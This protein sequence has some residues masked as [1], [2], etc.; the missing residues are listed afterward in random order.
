MARNNAPEIVPA[1]SDYLD[2][3]ARY[4]PDEFDGDQTSAQLSLQLA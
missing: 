1:A 3:K 4:M 2:S